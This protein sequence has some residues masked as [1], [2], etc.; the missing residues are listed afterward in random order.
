MEQTVNA[1]R[2]NLNVGPDR[3]ALEEML[4]RYQQTEETMLEEKLTQELMGVMQEEEGEAAEKEML[5]EVARI[6][7]ENEE[8]LKLLI[9]QAERENKERETIGTQKAVQKKDMVK[10]ESEGCIQKKS[11]ENEEILRILRMKHAEEKISAMGGSPAPTPP[12]LSVPECPVCTT[13]LH[14]PARIFHCSNGHLLCEGC[15][16]QSTIR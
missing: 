16:N 2:K 12:A 9:E 3:E 14:P 8:K 11:A 10:K 4:G 15:H 5:E 1:I 7:K 13:T 6:K